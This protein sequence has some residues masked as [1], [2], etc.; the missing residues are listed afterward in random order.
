MIRYAQRLANTL[1]GVN[2]PQPSQP[3]A[4]PNSAPAPMPAI[5]RPTYGINQP[6]GY[7]PAPSAQVP[8]QVG[9]G[10]KMLGFNMQ[11]YNK[12]KVY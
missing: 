12:N 3:M 11:P 9:Q 4:P 1:R 2:M 7:Q 10:A 8:A 5:Q 6:Q